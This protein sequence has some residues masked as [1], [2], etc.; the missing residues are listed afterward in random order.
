[1]DAGVKAFIMIRDDERTKF[2]NCLN[3]LENFAVDLANNYDDSFVRLTT[4]LNDTEILVAEMKSW[5]HKYD[6]GY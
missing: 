4:I 5:L 3:M 1:M 6:R 2:F